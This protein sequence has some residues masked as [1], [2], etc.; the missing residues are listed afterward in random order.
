MRINQ[1]IMAFN[2]YRNLTTTNTQLGK[3]L[4]KLSSGFRIN[5]AADDA[6]GLVVSEGLR[7]Q[8]SG[9]RVATRNAQDGVSVVQTAEGAL[10]E[11]HSMLRRMRDLAV[12]ASNTGANDADARA[13]A[14]A[15]IDELTAEVGR[16]SDKTK[17]GGTA[18]LDGTYGISPATVKSDTAGFAATG[19]SFAF[20][21]N[22]QFTVRVDG[23]AAVTVTLDASTRTADGLETY[24][25]NKIQGALYADNQDGS[26][27]TVKVTK[28]DTDTWR[29][30]IEAAV[31]SGA[32]LTLAN[33]SGT[34]LTA[35]LGINAGTLAD[36]ASGSGGVFQ[37]GANAGETIAVSID[38]MDA[39]ALGINALDV[40]TDASGAITAIDAAIKTVS[41][42]RGELGAVQNRFEHTVANLS[43][44]AE[45]LAASESRIRD[46]DM[47]L[48]LVDFTRHQ[49]LQ[50]A[51]TAM[52]AQANQVPSSVLSLLG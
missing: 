18:L 34:P 27:V 38:D 8:I 33:Q 26:K 39:T 41:T 25:Q 1:N 21:V 28:D 13:A 50:Q 9:L 14:Q 2:S 23:G 3:S 51:G 30:S 52:L 29:V 19:G 17:F 37:V 20:T 10:T 42:Q 49:I 44:T 31:A 43:V 48:E 46:T 4:E 15:E 16:I 35:Q 32:A 22:D 6:A 24:L 45:N 40:E 5:R 36:T 47:A 12:Q 11:V 7:A